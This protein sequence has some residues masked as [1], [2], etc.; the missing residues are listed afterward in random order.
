M[1][2]EHI[3]N[4][5]KWCTL[6]RKGFDEELR[7]RLWSRWLFSTLSSELDEMGFMMQ[8]PFPSFPIAD[9]AFRN[10]AFKWSVTEL[11]SANTLARPLPRATRHAGDS[12]GLQYSPAVRSNRFNT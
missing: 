10:A 1:A 6:P 4:D 11:Q 5:S 7:I 3:G 9:G 2:H 12:T 8:S